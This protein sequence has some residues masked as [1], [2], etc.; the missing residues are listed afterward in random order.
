MT[1]INQINMGRQIPNR[2]HARRVALTHNSINYPVKI[3]I[4][5]AYELATGQELPYDSFITQEAVR[6][7]MDLGFSI[8]E[9]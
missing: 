7:L 2:R 8:I 4:S 1:V 6:Y 3:L 5:W 9:I